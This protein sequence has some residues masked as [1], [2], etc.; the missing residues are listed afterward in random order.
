MKRLSNYQDS[1]HGIL[2]GEQSQKPENGLVKQSRT[3]AL[4]KISC[5]VSLDVPR[6]SGSKR[7]SATGGERG[8]NGNKHQNKIILTIQ[9]TGTQKPFGKRKKQ[10]KK[11]TRA[12][13]YGNTENQAGSN[14]NKIYVQLQCHRLG[15]SC[16]KQ[17][18]KAESKIKTCYHGNINIDVKYRSDF[19]SFWLEPKV[20]C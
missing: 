6:K 17:T 14:T 15:Y 3:K 18:K 13:G 10:V 1:P 8:S 11:T 2:E 7:E 20:K 5:L 16:Q 4:P 19:P 9:S 12:L